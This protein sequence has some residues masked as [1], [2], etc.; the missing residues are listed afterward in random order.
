MLDLL[1]SRM[2]FLFRVNE[3]LNLGHCEL[4][5]TQ[6]ALSRTDLVTERLSDWVV[7]QRETY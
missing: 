3:M 5:N 4:T 2:R 1:E 6:Q 7:N